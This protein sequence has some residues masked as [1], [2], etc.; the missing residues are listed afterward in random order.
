MQ[1]DLAY[2]DLLNK[3]DKDNLE[4]YL[5]AKSEECCIL[6]KRVDDLTINVDDQKEEMFLL[7]KE[8]ERKVSCRTTS[9]CGPLA[10]EIGSDNLKL[11]NDK[12]KKEVKRMRV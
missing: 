4:K 10:D 2:S 7:K 3:V 5:L 6:L 1:D 9:S 11:E 8:V 12:L